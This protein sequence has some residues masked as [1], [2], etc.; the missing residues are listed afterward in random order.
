[1]PTGSRERM[2]DAAVALFSRQGYAATSFNDI[3]EHSG[4]PRGSIYHH[5]PGGKAELAVEA[6][7]ST[8]ERVRRGLAAATAQGSASEAVRLFVT[9]LA[10]ALR[11]SDFHA[12][13][14]VAGVVLDTAADD[15]AVLDAGSAAFDTWRDALAEIFR[16]EGASPAKARRL[17]V[18]VVAATEGA[19]AERGIQP[20]TDVGRELDTHVRAA[21]AP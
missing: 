21:L 8:G 10:E 17:A 18:F 4:A 2:I 16:R 13:C 3:I 11:G 15:D 19:R 6:V 5:F 7:R 20:L 9:T 14:A 12:G 1:M